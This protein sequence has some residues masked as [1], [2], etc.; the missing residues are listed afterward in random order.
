MTEKKFFIYTPITLCKGKTRYGLILFATFGRRKPPNR[1][2]PLFHCCH[3][4][5]I[6]FNDNILRSNCSDSFRIV[7]WTQ[8]SR[9]EDGYW[10]ATGRVLCLKQQKLLKICTKFTIKIGTVRCFPSCG[11]FLP[12]VLA[13][14]E[15]F[16]EKLGDGRV[17]NACPKHA[18]WF[19]RPNSFVSGLVQTTRQ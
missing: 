14:M 5:F 11:I 4:S 2:V 8:E 9:L 18:F 13:A 15:N 1:R 12:H 3:V 16:E 17:G 10:G 6:R 7:F 19:F